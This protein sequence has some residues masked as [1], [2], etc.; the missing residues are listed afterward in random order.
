MLHANRSR[1]KDLINLFLDVD[2]NGQDATN[3]GELC[4]TTKNENAEH[5]HQIV[6]ILLNFNV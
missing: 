1:R 6:R 5:S 3:E 2:L 4:D